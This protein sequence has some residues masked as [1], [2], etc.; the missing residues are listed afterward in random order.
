MPAHQPE[1]PQKPQ[2]QTP[3]Q[4]KKPSPQQTQKPQQP[5]PLPQ[6]PP[7]SQPPPPPPPTSLTDACT[8]HDA[9]DLKVA[10]ENELDRH[11]KKISTWTYQ[12]AQPDVH[13]LPYVK[14]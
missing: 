3:Q 13:P 10:H 5:R 4:T 2:L 6:S 12:K 1:Q 8:R 14:T 9:A 11:E 7:Q